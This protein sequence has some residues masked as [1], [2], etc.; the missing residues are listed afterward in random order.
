[1]YRKFLNFIFF[2]CIIFL[3]SKNEFKRYYYDE[4]GFIKINNNLME[5]L[6][7]IIFFNIGEIL[8]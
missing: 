4:I 7:I 3:F 6:S 8:V 5:D 1:M 2:N